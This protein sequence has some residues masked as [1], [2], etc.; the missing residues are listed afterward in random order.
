MSASTD[1]T[2]ATS[3]PSRMDATRLAAILLPVA[4]LLLAV[5][6]WEAAVQLNEIPPYILPAPSQIAATLVKDWPVLFGSLL[7][8]LRITFLALF[9]AV[10]GGVLLAI[11]FAQS[12]WIELSFFPFAVILQ[13]T[14]IVAIAP[15]LLIYLEPGTAVL[16]CAFLV[17]F[18]PIL[19]NTALGLASADHNLRDLF[20]LYGAS[21]FKQLI[22]LRLP[23]ALPYFLGG[24]RIGGGLALIGAIVAEIAAGTA[25]Q[26]SGLAFRII[27]SGYRLNIPRMFAALFLISVAGIL[28]FLLF[29]ALSHL[30]LHRWHESARKREA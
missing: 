24:L 8:T 29:T 9:A 2:P 10:V 11:L 28:I 13:V 23:A 14:P 3:G 19:S 18:F 30:L 7:V 16:V 15:L 12:R 27:E 4:I 26:G 5:A 1:D 21:R 22:Y 20:D 17:A 6:G 25:G